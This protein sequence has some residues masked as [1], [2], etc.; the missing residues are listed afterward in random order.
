MKTYFQFVLVGIAQ[1]VALLPLRGAE[2]QT[3]ASA[4]GGRGD[5]RG[6]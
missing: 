3:V 6:P 2:V 4:A 1:V 5:D